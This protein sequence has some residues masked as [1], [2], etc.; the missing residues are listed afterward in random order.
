[1]KPRAIVN[2]TQAGETLIRYVKDGR[3]VTGQAMVKVN[4]RI[5]QAQAER[6]AGRLSQAIRRGLDLFEAEEAMGL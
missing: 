1:M 5:P 4:A 2:K 3:K 6:L